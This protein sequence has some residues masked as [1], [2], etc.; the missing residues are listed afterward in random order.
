MK[1][2]L[3]FGSFNPVHTGHMIIAN[4]LVHYTDM[5][6]VW[7]VVSPQNPLKSK[8]SLANNN[9]RYHL[10]QLAID[11]NHKLRASN[12]EFSLPIPSYTI[13]T[14]TYLKE[15]YPEK[16]FC[17]IMGGDNL[18]TIDKWKNYHLLLEHYDIYV[19][20]RPGYDLG[21]YAQNPRVQILDNVPM[22][23]I[24]ATFIR[25]ALKS[26]KSVQYLVPEK[27]FDYLSK[28][29]MYK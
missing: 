19:Y 25:E 13:D 6:E 9:D 29:N 21:Q 22:L 23:D 27:V 28:Y 4:H 12:I 24:S 2:G 8:A 15:K 10:L 3:F 17:L 26:G 14:L 16:T 5:D 7:M 11:D 1:I 20:N 18:A